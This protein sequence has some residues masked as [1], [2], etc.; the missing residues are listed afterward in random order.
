M[1]RMIWVVGAVQVFLAAGIALGQDAGN[2][3]SARSVQTQ[4]GLVPKFRVDPSWPK[5]P[6]EWVFGEVSGVAVDAQDHVWVLQ[7]PRTVRGADKSKVAPPVL[8]FDA[9]GNF[10]TAWGG[11]GNGYEWPGTEHGVYVDY[12]GY[13]WISGS[14]Q[15]DDQILKFTQ[16]GEFVTQIGRSGQSGGNQDSKNV[17]MAAD[18]FVYPKTNELFVADGYG[19]RRVIVYDADTGAFKRMWGAFGNVPTDFVP[20]SP[21]GDKAPGRSA[22]NPGAA[23]PGIEDGR[24]PEQFTIVHGAR[25][26]NDDIVYVSDRGSRRFQVFTLDGRFVTQ[27]FI[28]RDKK[29]AEKALE[30]RDG[31]TA[32]DK[33]IK[34]LNQQ[35]FK[36]GQTVSRTAFSPDPQQRFMYVINRIQQQIV[37]YD[38]KTL[39]VLGAFGQTGHA[40]GEFYVLHDMA[41]DSKGNIYTAEVNEG[42]RAQKFAIQ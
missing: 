39:E 7:R 41:V 35:L 11:P 19:N 17:H 10:I 26:S 21:A 38:R 33:P 1:T 5:I 30:S 29:T 36:A 16:K 13:V 4:T 14:G 28:D 9:A 27:V 3:V 23:A 2:R 40:P 18:L 8:E 22:P 12:K 20:Q 15:S 24:G 37:I 6:N 42:R 34:D 25:V 31:D 32:F